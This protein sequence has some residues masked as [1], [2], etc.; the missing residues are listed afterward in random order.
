MKEISQYLPEDVQED[1][2]EQFGFEAD[3]EGLEDEPKTK[4]KGLLARITSIF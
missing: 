3:L 4:R 1:M 2:Y